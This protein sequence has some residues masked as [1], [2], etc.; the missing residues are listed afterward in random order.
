VDRITVFAPG[1]SSNLGAGFDCLGLAITGRGD[2]VT[3]SRSEYPG[4]RV[5][6]VS[7]PRIPLE[8]NR[9]T[10][11]LAAAAVMRH[12]REEF[13]LE[14]TIEKGLPLAGGLGGSAAS[15]V[16]GAVAAEAIVQANLSRDHLLAAALEA[17]AVV[18]GGR[19]VDNVAPSL[20][21]G[22]VLIVSLDPL[23]LTTLKVHP[24]F[25]FVL[26]TPDYTVE[27]AKARALLPS[28]ISRQDAVD[29]AAHLGGLVLG[30]ERGDADL[31]RDCMSDR[32]AEPARASLFPGY[33]HAFAAG[34]EAGAAGVAVSGAGPT[35]IAVVAGG[36]AEPVATAMVDAYARKGI[37][38]TSHRARLDR[39]GARVVG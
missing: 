39:A 21:G 13:G 5:V 24:S 22:A 25:S 29:Q 17:E 20:L 28:E 9:N 37:P 36:N 8:D 30:L 11:A 32:I 31:I 2:S 23:R 15:A 27:T 14:L 35:L 26:V 18:S 3:A 1:S 16:A 10:A 4:V 19:H 6:S 33:L 38:A 34:I 12:A 7:D